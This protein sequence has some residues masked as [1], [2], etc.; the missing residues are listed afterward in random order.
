[1]LFWLFLYIVALQVH[2]ET[3]LDAAT[4]LL[5]DASGLLQFSRFLSWCVTSVEM[6]LSVHP[7]AGDRLPHCHKGRLWAVNVAGVCVCV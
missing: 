4:S 7:C 1:M 3:R 2:P 6:G 5:Q